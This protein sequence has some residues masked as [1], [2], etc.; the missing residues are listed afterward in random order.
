[1]RTALSSPT[2]SARAA[3]PKH[4]AVSAVVFVA[5]AERLQSPP[6]GRLAQLGEHQ[7][8]K[9]GVTGSSPV[10]PT[11]KTPANRGF[12]FF[13]EKA[14]RGSCAQ[15]G[16]SGA[17]R[18]RR[19]F[20]TRFRC[21]PK[22]ESSPRRCLRRQRPHRTVPCTLPPTRTELASGGYGAPGLRLP[23]GP[24][25]ATTGTP[26]TAAQIRAPNV[27]RDRSIGLLL[28][29]GDDTDASRYRSAR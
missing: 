5:A 18:R 9:L 29:P 25:R 2:L 6:R 1:V 21:R 3:V 11:T 17:R 19:S 7:L 23:R 16:R 22:D 14:L 28:A 24:V 20:G 15:N 8:D 12:W 13:S 26:P 10:P 4:A 27:F